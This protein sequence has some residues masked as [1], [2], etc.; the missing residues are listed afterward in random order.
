MDNT[1]S[2]ILENLK[3]LK[4]KYKEDGF[5]ILGLFGSYSRNE[6]IGNSDID[7]LYDLD[8]KLF[9]S[10]YRGFEAFNRLLQIKEELKNEFKSEIDIA[11]IT[12]LNKT[13]KEI[14]LKEVIYV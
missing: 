2:E 8:D 4:S 10:K 12:T 5:L 7:I 9:I 14:I 1:K 11:D 3:N 6:A 13:A